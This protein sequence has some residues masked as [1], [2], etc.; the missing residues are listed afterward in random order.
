MN[1][2]PAPLRYTPE[3]W[4]AINKADK[5]FRRAA[6]AWEDG[7]NSGNNATLTRKEKE[8]DDLRNKAE[9]LLIPYGIT[10]DYPGLFPT[11]EYQGHSY[12]TAQSLCHWINVESNRQ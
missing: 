9:K 6:K 11:Y 10:V 12:Y 2:Q 5:L 1:T 7:N 4:N 8:C 3:L